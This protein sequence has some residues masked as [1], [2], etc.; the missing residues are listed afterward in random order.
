MNIAYISLSSNNTEYFDILDTLYFYDFTKLIVDFE[1]LSEKHFPFYLKIDWGDGNIET[2]D[3]D[4]FS[5]QNID[6]KSSI[7]NLTKDHEYYPSKTSLYKQLS[8][9]F[10]LRYTN[11]QNAWFIQPIILRNYDYFESIEDLEIV[12]VDVSPSESNEK[13]I[14]LKTKKNSYIIDLIE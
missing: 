5:A 3:N 9:Q 1:N 2:F 14:H 12:G 10:F 11:G 8:A 13:H 4:V 7:F 6:K